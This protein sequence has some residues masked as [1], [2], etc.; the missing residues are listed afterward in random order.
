MN[1]NLN[2]SD[3]MKSVLL[4]VLGASQSELD[5][6]INELREKLRNY[7]Y[8]AQNLMTLFIA[9]MCDISVQDM[10]SIGGSVRCAQARFLLCYALRYLLGYS[11]VELADRVEFNGERLTRD[12]IRKGVEVM[13]N[14]IKNKQGGW[15]KRWL[16]LASIFDDENIGV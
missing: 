14:L 5:V 16:I 6:C 7:E 15:H 10:M 4:D 1:E 2:N 12:G 3:S 8:N 13:S 9:S 11:Y